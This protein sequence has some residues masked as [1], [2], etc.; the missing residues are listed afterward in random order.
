[1]AAASSL[2]LEIK[3]LSSLILP[4]GLNQRDRVPMLSSNPR[5]N[6]SAVAFEDANLCP[7]DS[8]FRNLDGTQPQEK[9]PHPGPC[10]GDLLSLWKKTNEVEKRRTGFGQ[11]DPIGRLTALLMFQ[12]LSH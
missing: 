9:H 2:R 8:A 10:M 7:L 12:E 6:D 3:H 4:L 11:P 5:R 1:M